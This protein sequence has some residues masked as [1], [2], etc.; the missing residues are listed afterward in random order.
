ME[1]PVRHPVMLDPEHARD[2]K[3][4]LHGAIGFATK[5][6]PE[7]DDALYLRLGSRVI[8]AIL[9][10][11]PGHDLELS[12]LLE[13]TGFTPR[14]MQRR[15]GVSWTQFTE[16]VVRA[17]FY[18]A[19]RR[20]YYEEVCS[21]PVSVGRADNS[22]GTDK[23]KGAPQSLHLLVLAIST[24]DQ[25]C[26]TLTWPLTTR[27][28]DDR[29]ISRADKRRIAKFEHQL[30]SPT[31]ATLAD[32]LR[33]LLAPR[34]DASRIPPELTR[35]VLERRRTMMF[36][37]Y[38]LI[39]DLPCGP[40]PHSRLNPE[41]LLPGM[42][43]AV[44]KVVV[45]HRRRGILYC[46]TAHMIDPSFISINEPLPAMKEL[47]IKDE[48][49][50]EYLWSEEQELLA[51]QIVNRQ[52]VLTEFWRLV[53]VAE[54]DLPDAMAIIERRAQNGWPVDCIERWEEEC[55]PGLLGPHAPEMRSGCIALLNAANAA[56]V[57]AERHAQ[58]Q[59]RSQPH[60][61][62]GR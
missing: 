43:D 9:A 47:S 1:Q 15:F 56:L 49:G 25:H 58:M 21:V 23:V 40:V 45:R 16:L 44:Q 33:R 24:I 46:G 52:G 53:L 36:S 48:F 7:V 8:D 61:R 28:R 41:R 35:P 10:G 39:A 54:K 22:L 30:G 18:N 32:N 62:Q 55:S 31:P 51:R 29:T 34:F 12:D 38:L 5:Y 26:P 42:D 3:R 27:T 37:P 4:R 14:Q 50:V 60:P 57:S 20:V 59:R 6:V 11:R 2:A 13:G 17:T 19:D